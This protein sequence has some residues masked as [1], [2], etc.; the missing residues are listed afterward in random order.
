[1][2]RIARMIAACAL[3]VLPAVAHA[4]DKLA[5]TG[6]LRATFIDT[7]TAQARTDPKTGAVSGPAADLAKALAEKLGVPL[8]LKPARGVAGVIESVKT[9]EAD[10]GFVAYD[11]IRATEV[12][13]SQTY[14]L[15]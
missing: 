1:M 9:G 8:T 4:D 11:P 15:A 13:F 6:T 10:I 3:T 2:S 5:P 12:D 14:M 7:N